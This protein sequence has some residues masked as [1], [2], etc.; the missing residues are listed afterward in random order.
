MNQEIRQTVTNK[1]NLLALIAGI[2]LFIGGGV[3][4]V[5]LRSGYF[6]FAVLLGLAAI[7][8]T[9]ISVG[10]A[11]KDISEAKPREKTDWTLFKYYLIMGGIF[12]LE[13]GLLYLIFMFMSTAKWL[14][15]LT[16]LGIFIAIAV[17]L[18]VTRV[19]EKTKVK[20]VNEVLASYLR[21]TVWSVLILFGVFAILV[22]VKTVSLLAYFR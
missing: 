20:P 2:V 3:G 15:V 7:V 19:R 12:L 9:A 1:K 10:S 11:R 17:F 13:F 22:I 16:A 6:L 14:Y 4:V 18:I 8:Y 21:V 5:A